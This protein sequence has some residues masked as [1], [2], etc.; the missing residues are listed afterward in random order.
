MKAVS[1]AMPVHSSSS[2]FFVV[3][4]HVF[5]YLNIFFPKINLEFNVNFSLSFLAIKV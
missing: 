2:F 4:D 3:N 5:L 1:L